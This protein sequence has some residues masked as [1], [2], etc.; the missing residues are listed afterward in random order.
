[1]GESKSSRFLSDFNAHSEKQA[2]FRPCKINRL[3]GVSE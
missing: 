3:A 2:I 1:M